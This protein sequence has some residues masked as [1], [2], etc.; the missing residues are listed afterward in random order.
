LESKEVLKS[1]N[2]QE[3]ERFEI[4]EELEETSIV[5]FAV[6]K[7]LQLISIAC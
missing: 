7:V 1:F 5:A 4:S 2:L 3:I 6:E